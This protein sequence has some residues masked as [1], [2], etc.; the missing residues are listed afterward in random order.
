MKMRPERE[1]GLF[2][3]LSA[4]WRKKILMLYPGE[5]DR[6]FPRIHLMASETRFDRGWEGGMSEKN[7]SENYRWL[8][9]LRTPVR[10]AH[11]CMGHE[12]LR[13]R[14][15]TNAPKPSF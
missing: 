3:A 7:R 1:I 14:R 9:G 12:H 11:S 2:R 10:I 5:T 4:K 6:L 8:Y 13:E 15:T